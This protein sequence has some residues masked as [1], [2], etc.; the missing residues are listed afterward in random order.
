MVLESR[1]L[2][3]KLLP[4][5]FNAAITVLLFALLAL[6]AFLNWT[7]AKKFRFTVGAA[8]SVMLIL[9]MGA[10]FYYLNAALRTISNITA[11]QI[12]VTHVSVY[13]KKDSPVATVEELLGQNMGILSGMNRE[14]TDETLKK[15]SDALGQDM[16]TREYPRMEELATALRQGEVTAVLCD[17]GYFALLEEA[18]GFGDFQN[19]IREIAQ[20]R[21]EREIVKPTVPAS[22]QSAQESREQQ[23]NAYADPA[24]FLMFPEVM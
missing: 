15:L 10:G 13:V 20:I 22:T 6:A 14:N 9:G 1:I 18:E 17:G 21:V 24:P 11:P 16:Q 12:Q 7:T 4:G 3:S 23:E 5:K 8:L 19:E 2:A